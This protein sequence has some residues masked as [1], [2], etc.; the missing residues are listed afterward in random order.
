[1][2]NL[3]TGVIVVVTAEVLFAGKISG[4]LAG[5]ATEAPLVIDPIVDAFTVPV[6]LSTTVLPTGSCG[7]VAAMLL[8]EI[9]N[10]AGHNAPPLA[11]MQVAV[12]AFKSAGELS[13]KLAL[14]T[15]LGPLFLITKLY[16]ML[17]PASTV[18][19]PVFWMDRSALALTLAA[20]LELLLL[21]FGSVVPLGAITLAVFTIVPV[22][23]PESVPLMLTV[24][25]E[26]AGKVAKIALTVLP[27]TLTLAGHT[28]PPVLALQ[29]ALTPVIPTGTTSVKL[30]PLALLGP[31][32]LITTL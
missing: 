27:L 30:A 25:L 3:A 7:N 6:I 24:T 28:A 10:P 14:K 17:A 19:G 23:V 26:P 4:V 9:E 18:A 1:M 16:V 32:L 2:P 5:V 13:E 8:P 22:A 31:A 11:L 15:S 29:L 21:G 12:I 20:V